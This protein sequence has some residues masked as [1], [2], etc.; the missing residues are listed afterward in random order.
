MDSKEAFIVLNLI[1]GIGP[2][3][4]RKLLEQFG[5]PQKVLAASKLE[6]LRVNGIGEE[7]ADAITGWES[8]VKLDQE[9]KAIESSGCRVIT[10]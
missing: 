10:Q 1:E 5:E 6:L 8:S 2:I 4:V 3:R 9:M 7:V